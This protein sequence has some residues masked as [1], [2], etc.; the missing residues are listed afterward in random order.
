[1][2]AN[3]DGTNSFSNSGGLTDTSTSRNVPR[4]SA[5]IYFFFEQ[6][7]PAFRINFA[8]VFLVLYLC[9]YFSKHSCSWV[10]IRSGVSPLESPTVQWKHTYEKRILTVDSAQS[11]IHP[12]YL[13]ATLPPPPSPHIYTLIYLTPL[14]IYIYTSSPLIHIYAWIWSAWKILFCKRYYPVCQRRSCLSLSL[15]T[16]QCLIRSILDS[17]KPVM[18]KR[19]MTN[20]RLTLACVLPAWVQTEISEFQVRVS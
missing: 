14:Y 8:F 12:F 4:C 17:N 10:Q 1:M 9:C 11:T 2:T 19:Y 18:H 7:L 6:G 5:G 20:R 3:Y 15:Q 16:A 13:L